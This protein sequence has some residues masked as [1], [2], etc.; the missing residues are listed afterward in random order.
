MQGAWFPAAWTGGVL[1]P[2]H[3]GAEEWAAEHTSPVKALTCGLSND[4]S[5]AV[6]VF[7]VIQASLNSP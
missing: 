6:L 3:L 5:G 2:G 7:R 1:Q 4:S